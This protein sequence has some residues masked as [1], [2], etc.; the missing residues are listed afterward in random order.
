[1]VLLRVA[2]LMALAI[3][4]GGLAVLGFVAAPAIFGALTAQDAT[5]GRAA[6]GAVFGAVLGRF[7]YWTWII[8]AVLIVLL[9]LRALIG[10]RPRRLSWRVGLV[11][12]MLGLSLATAFV[13]SPRIDAIR[14][15]TAASGS[16][17][18]L[19]DTDP[20]KAEFGRLHA[21]SNVAMLLTLLLGAGLI[22]AEAADS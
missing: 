6:A 8:G 1:M 13:F 20:R 18:A 15:A 5:G 17:A 12:A 22:W 2:S 14:Q 21:F 3:W 19:P 11:V 7:Q 4:V 10:P 16:I 9:V